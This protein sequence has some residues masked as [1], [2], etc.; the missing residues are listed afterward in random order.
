VLI[1]VFFVEL[2]FRKKHER[3]FEITIPGNCGAD[4]TNE[5]GRLDQKVLQPGLQ[6][7]VIPQ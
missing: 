4:F 2:D 7:R 5:Q 3:V 6:T 1:C